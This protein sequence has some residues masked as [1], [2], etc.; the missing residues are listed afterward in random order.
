MEKYN[1][2][3]L[4]DEFEQLKGQFIITINHTVER[5]IAIGDDDEDYYWVTWDGKDLH[6]SSCA[7][8]IIP[9]KGYL[10][11]G[12]YNELIRLAKLNHFDSILS[13][14]EFSRFLQ[15]YI[16]KYPKNHKILTRLYF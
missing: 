11:D 9:L 13:F 8:R 4:L 15:D 6:W 1:L 12:D 7:G 3:K 5:L 10:K 2:D 16:S 14:E